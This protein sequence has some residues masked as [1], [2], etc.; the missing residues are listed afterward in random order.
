MPGCVPASYCPT[1][2]RFSVSPKRYGES[3]LMLYFGSHQKVLHIIAGRKRLASS[4]IYSD[5]LILSLF[6][7]HC[8]LNFELSC[9]ATQ[10]IKLTTSE[11]LTLMLG[12]KCIAGLL[13]E[14]KNNS[15]YLVPIGNFP[16]ILLKRFFF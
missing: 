14:L 8:L 13:W 7:Q 9:S 5:R 6:C 11:P 15:S 3:T 16:P 12:R 10:A 1:G 2:L 4:C